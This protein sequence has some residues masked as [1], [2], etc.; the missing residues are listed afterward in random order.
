VLTYSHDGYGLG[1][2]RRNLR[3]LDALLDEL[4]DAAALMV[5]G[6]QASHR[7]EFPDHVDYLKLPSLAKV[8]NDHYVSRRLGLNRSEVASL[9]S[10]LVAA[11]V[12]QFEP[13]LVL[14]DFY[15]V[16]VYGELEA[17]LGRVRALFPST[18]VVLGW[19]DILDDPAQV[20]REWGETGQIE[21]A[22]RLFDRV[23]VYGCRDIYDP[24]AEYAL[25]AGLASRTTFTGYLIDE[26]EHAAPTASR[27]GGPMV[28]C[29]V[30]GGEDGAPVAWA[31]LE[32]MADLSR[33]GWSGVLV[34]GPLM[35]GDDQRALSEHAAH[36]NVIC[37]P[38][39][40]DMAGLLRRAE[41]VV[42]MAG[43]NT[44]CEVF[45]AR[46]P[47]V[48]VPRVAP[49]QEQLLRAS[50]MA[51]RGLVRLLHPETMSGKSLA[52]AVRAQA[53]IGREE[54]GARLGSRL[55]G[56]GLRRAASVLAGHVAT[57]PARVPA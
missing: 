34:T 18:P 51:E 46:V 15:P 2:L 43:Y 49:R 40:D 14:I 54:I 33:H 25:P 12:E 4:P 55:D 8:A 19:R 48:M 36:S 1:H 9:R 23:L 22:D 30:G 41:V 44:V 45:A 32:A 37:V 56:G 10:A 7:F 28:V 35:Q 13:D 29:T 21:A 50:R 6:S 57:R 5:A 16:G 27:E 24:I 17:A 39:V 42:A 53:E 3:L 52:G 26:R 47:A 31:F 11:A 20:R 38:F